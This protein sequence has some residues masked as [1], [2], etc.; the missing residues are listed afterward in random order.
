VNFLINGKVVATKVKPPFQLLWNAKDK[1]PGEYTLAARAYDRA[2]NM[3]EYQ[4]VVLVN[5]THPIGTS[6]SSVDQ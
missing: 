3:A 4:T 6:C 5:T 2:R 1:A